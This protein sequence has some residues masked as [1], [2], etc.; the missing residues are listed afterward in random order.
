VVGTLGTG[1]QDPIDRIAISHNASTA[2]EHEPLERDGPDYGSLRHVGNK[3]A[4]RLISF[5]KIMQSFGC[6]LRQTG[7]A[8]FHAVV[9]RRGA[10]PVFRYVK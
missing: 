3:L 10:Q 8:C 7:A 1:A 4:S 2:L 6:W 5:F 9:G